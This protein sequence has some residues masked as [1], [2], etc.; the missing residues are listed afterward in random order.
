MGVDSPKFFI[1]IAILRELTGGNQP[2]SASFALRSLALQGN[3]LSQTEVVGDAPEGTV[4]R[5][6]I[7]HHFPF[8]VKGSKNLFGVKRFRWH[9]KFSGSALSSTWR[10]FTFP[11]RV[12]S[13]V[14]GFLAFRDRRLSREVIKLSN[15]DSRKNRLRINPPFFWSNKL[16]DYRL[17]SGSGPSRSN[18]QKEVTILVFIVPRIFRSFTLVIRTSSLKKPQEMRTTPDFVNHL[19]VT[20]RILT[21]KGLDIY[22]GPMFGGSEKFPHAG[23]ELI[24]QFRSLNTKESQ[25]T[26]APLSQD[27]RCFAS[28]RLS[29]RLSKILFQRG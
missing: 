17:L 21:H 25:V 18:R 15:G 9:F 23:L 4:A 27:E 10:S 14:L 8:F 26:S 24:S 6:T 11:S 5:P 7:V 12:F 3:A 1:F 16:F 13:I 29:K 20:P 19:N 28:L 2:Q 22:I